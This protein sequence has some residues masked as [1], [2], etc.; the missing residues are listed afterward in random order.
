MLV[1]HP[2]VAQA[3]VIAREDGPG[4]KRLGH[5]APTHK[6]IIGT[7]NILAPAERHRMLRTWNDTARSIPAVTGRNCSPHRLRGHRMRL[8]PCSRKKH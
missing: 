7:S 6:Q 1:R 5:E 2:G 3:A 8:Q 4:D